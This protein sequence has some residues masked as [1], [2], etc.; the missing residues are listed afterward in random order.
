[1]KVCYRRVSRAVAPVRADTPTPLHKPFRFYYTCALNFALAE[2]IVM[3][4][5]N[6]DPY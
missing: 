1:M 5:D 6:C 2:Q 3:I 4:L